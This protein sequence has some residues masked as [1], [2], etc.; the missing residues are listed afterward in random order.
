MK[1]TGLNDQVSE[2][3]QSP[4]DDLGKDEALSALIELIALENQHGKDSNNCNQS[5]EDIKKERMT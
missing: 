1:L 5:E 2:K 3:T 4:T